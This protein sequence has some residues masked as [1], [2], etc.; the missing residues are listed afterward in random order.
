MKQIVIGITGGTGCGKTTALHT[1]EELGYHIIDCDALYHTL[2]D[3]DEAMLQ[4]ISLQF[5]GTVSGGQLQR[6]ELGRQ[7]F[8]DPAALQRLNDTVWPYVHRAVETILSRQAP[9]PC[10][11]DAIGLM[12]SGLSRLCDRTVAVTAPEEARIRRLMDREGIEEAYARLRVRAQ[13]PNEYFSGLCHVTLENAYETAD[14]FL[15]HC[16]QVFSRLQ[17]QLIKEEPHHE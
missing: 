4:A 9:R 8:S 11:I 5:P 6:K 3:T 14:E 12:E 16:R 1:L 15:A 13:Q 17:E 2:L 10:A 7:V